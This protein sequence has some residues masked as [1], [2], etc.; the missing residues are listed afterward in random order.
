M[1][2][3]IYNPI[4]GAN[5]HNETFEK[6]AD[7]FRQANLDFVAHPTQKK[8]HATEFVRALTSGEEPVDI[9]V[10]G[11]DGTF[12]EALNGV[13]NFDNVR[14]GLIPA[15]T[16]NDFARKTG[17]P[18]NPKKA[19]DAITSGKITN[20]DYIQLAN[21][22]RVFNV[23]GAGMD[24]DVLVRYENMKHFKGRIKYY[25]SLFDTLLHVRFHK[26]R[27]TTAEGEVKDESVFMI[28][29]ANGTYI[30]GGIPISPESI[31]TDGEMDVVYIKEMKPSLIL[32]RLVGFLKGNH[33]GK[34]YAVSFRTKAVKV[35]VLDEG[36][37]QIDGEVLDE[38]VLDATIVHG[39]LKIFGEL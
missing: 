3:I 24:V 4:S 16:G 10:I 38:K 12:S 23:A 21:G 7:M 33:I 28:A 35:E 20:V 26:V 17:I 22:E 6:V 32:P 39:A 5:K 2:H 8:G 9:I 15:G 18:S 34:D 37:I 19:F 11:G 27:I 1:Y 31:V 25:L 13:V 30:G 14:F 29:V 36:K